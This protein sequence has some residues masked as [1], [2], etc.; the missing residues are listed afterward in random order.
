MTSLNAPRKL[1]RSDDRTPFRC[2]AAELTEWLAKYAWQNQDAHNATTYVITD[3]DH[4][5]GFYAIAMAAIA[6]SHAPARM[7]AHRPSQIPCILLARLAVDAD[8]AGRGLGWQLLRDAL[9]RS[10]QLS[11]SIGATAVLVHCRDADARSF[12][13]HH[14]DFLPS[15]VDDLHLMVPMKTLRRLVSGD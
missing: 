11:N 8:Y 4:V 1:R 6:R 12:Y 5:V 13:M 10:V 3:G 15:P 7:T 9:A 14:G 2:A